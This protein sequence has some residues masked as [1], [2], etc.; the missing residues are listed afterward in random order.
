[1][2]Y[3]ALQI[4]SLDDYIS[5]SE[6]QL[7]KLHGSWNWAREVDTRIEEIDKLGSW[8]LVHLLIERAAEL[9]ISDRY[10]IATDKPIFK[11][12]STALFPAIAIPVETK[13]SYECPSKH[14]DA[15]KEFLP[16]VTKILIIGWRAAEQTFLSLLAKALPAKDV[17]VLVIAGGEEAAQQT[18]F[19]LRQAG[20]PGNYS[21][22]KGGFTD[23]IHNR[24]GDGFLKE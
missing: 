23:F 17:K 9:K 24:R 16:Q 13:S 2:A 5:H 19:Q 4:E 21:N 7:I 1:M 11:T 20:V 22:T 6:Y 10:Q 18:I 12:G 14:L 8:P 3:G 15:L